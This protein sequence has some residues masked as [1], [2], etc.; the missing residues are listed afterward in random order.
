MSLPYY[1]DAYGYAAIDAAPFGVRHPVKRSTLV[2]WSLGKK[3]CKGQVGHHKDGNKL[4]DNP[5]NLEVISHSEHSHQHNYGAKRSESAKERM[6]QAA[7]A[8]RENRSRA[9]S[10]RWA[11][12]DAYV[13]P[14]CAI[15][16]KLGVKTKTH[17]RH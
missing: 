12:Q 2:L 13:P 11:K 6:V 5:S 1:V 8:N 15:C 16:N 14:S 3:P 10:A 17:G 7:L 4:N 9:A